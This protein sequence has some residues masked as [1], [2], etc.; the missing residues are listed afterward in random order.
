MS[1]G[2]T[3]TFCLRSTL[4]PTPALEE[5]ELQCKHY[6]I[7]PLVHSEKEQKD[8]SA[9]FPVSKPS[10]TLTHHPFHVPTPHRLEKSHIRHFLSLSVSKSR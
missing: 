9:Q 1:R 10:L 8:D 7:D 4:P 6:S 2:I 3:R 5:V